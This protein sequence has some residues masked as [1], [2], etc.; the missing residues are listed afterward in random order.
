MTLLQFEDLLQSEGDEEY[1]EFEEFDDTIIEIPLNKLQPKTIN[2]SA[3]P[4]YSKFRP[5]KGSPL[6]NAVANRDP[7][8]TPSKALALG[9]LANSSVDAHATNDEYATSPPPNTHFNKDFLSRKNTI[10]KEAIR[11]SSGRIGAEIEESRKLDAH[12][13]PASPILPIWEPTYPKVVNSHD[14]QDRQSPDDPPPFEPP[15]ESASLK[16][17]QCIID[18][19]NTTL[20]SLQ[21][22]EHQAQH[23]TP[24][25]PNAIIN[26]DLLDARISK[27][28]TGYSF[29]EPEPEQN[30]EAASYHMN[31]AIHNKEEPEYNIPSIVD[32]ANISPEKSIDQ[33]KDDNL[34]GGSSTPIA[35]F[36]SHKFEYWSNKKWMKLRKIVN[37][38]TITREDA[39]N[40][41]LLLNEFGCVSKVEFQ[42]RYDYIKNLEIKHRKRKLRKDRI[43]K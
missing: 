34:Y 22:K 11:S 16:A 32:Q 23:P 38:A 1:E 40:S 17:R 14:T 36:D 31:V 5:S 19:V 21:K 27:D 20:E 26:S 43:G 7:S 42:N 28:D 3:K 39:I 35:K 15:I 29:S 18:K 41:P 2:G 24:R 30:L 37:S 9:E 6:R 13:T 33:M 12:V 25:E 4:N 10:G 8:A